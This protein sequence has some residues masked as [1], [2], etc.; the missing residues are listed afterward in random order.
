M[1]VHK[2]IAASI[3]AAVKTDKAQAKLGGYAGPYVRAKH[4]KS[5]EE[6]S[7][8]LQTILRGTKRKR[9]DDQ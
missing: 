1:P 8:R 9:D 3:K 6:S 5:K 7:E 4:Q 2:R